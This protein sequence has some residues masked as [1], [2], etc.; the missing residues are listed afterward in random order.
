MEVLPP[1]HLIS[2]THQNWSAAIGAGSAPNA[3]LNYRS[4]LL[5]IYFLIHLDGERNGATLVNYL[6]SARHSRVQQTQFVEEY[7]DAVKEYNKRLLVYKAEAEVFNEA[8]LDYRQEIA[9]YNQ[10]IDIYNDQVR[11]GVIVSERI[12][13]GPQPGNAPAPPQKPG[14]PKILTQD[15]KEQFPL[16]LTAIEKQARA[17]LW[18]ERN[19][20]QVWRQ[21]RDA[22]AQVGVSATA[23]NR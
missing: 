17:H 21:M 23:V 16:D 4:A 18:R 12:D 2:L 3:E 5:L 19:L 11:K 1:A 6:Q 10:R 13:V 14:L 8:L 7:N 22:L 15:P 9:N 20:D